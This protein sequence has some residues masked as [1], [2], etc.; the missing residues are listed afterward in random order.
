MEASI[1]LL[2]VRILLFRLLK[3]SYLS[4]D[5]DLVCG[6]LHR[7]IMACKS[8]SLAVNVVVPFII[9]NANERRF[10]LGR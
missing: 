3:V 7:W 4:S 9:N 1:G 8:D 6:S 10:L 2:E 5:F